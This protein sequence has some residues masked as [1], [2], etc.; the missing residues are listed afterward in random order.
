M[1]AA[2]SISRMVSNRVESDH[3]TGKKLMKS[4]EEIV[5]LMMPVYFVPVAIDAEER[6]LAQMT[7]NLILDDKSLEFLA[8][9]GQPDFSYQSCVTFFF[10]TFYTRLFDVHPMSRHLFKGGMRAQGKFLVKM[11]SLSLSEI[12]DPEKFTRNLLK[13]AEIHYEK[14]VKSVECKELLI[15]FEFFLNIFLFH[16]C[17]WC[18][19]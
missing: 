2:P 1:G 18:S 10:D 3:K 6:K 13:L 8:R 14:G 15:S 7:W 19:W 17:R 5:R 11:I 4:E 9:K 16:L 12:D